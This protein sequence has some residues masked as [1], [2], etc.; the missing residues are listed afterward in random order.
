MSSDESRLFSD[1]RWGAGEVTSRAR[2]V[3]W[4]GTLVQLRILDEYENNN[5]LALGAKESSKDTSSVGLS[6][7][8]CTVKTRRVW[9]S[10]EGVLT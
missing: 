2:G 4:R 9:A 1:S 7:N 8:L 10:H 5:L 3:N 6:N